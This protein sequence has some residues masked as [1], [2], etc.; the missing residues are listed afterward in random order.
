[1]G[2]AVSSTVQTLLAEGRAVMFKL[3]RSFVNVC[4]CRKLLKLIF[5][6]FVSVVKRV[7]LVLFS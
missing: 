7:I 3:V 1:M 6:Y 5:V 4:H 2:E